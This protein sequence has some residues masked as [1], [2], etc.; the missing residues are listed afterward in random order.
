MYPHEKL[1][2]NRVELITK[3]IDHILKSSKN[4]NNSIPYWRLVLE[5]MMFDLNIS[6]EELKLKWGISSYDIELM[7][8]G[9]SPSRA[10]SRTLI[11][12]EIKI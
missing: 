3:C 8:L 7:A 4:L 6:S 10:K 2:E 1:S 9:F 5:H 11:K 12:D